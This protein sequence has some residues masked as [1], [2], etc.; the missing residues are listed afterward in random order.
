MAGKFLTF[1]AVLYSVTQGQAQ[2]RT[3]DPS[4]GANLWGIAN[5]WAEGTI[6]G[7]N[8][9]VIFNNDNG[10]ISPDFTVDLALDRTVLGVDLGGDTGFTFLDVDNTLNLGSGGITTS[11]PSSGSVTHVFNNLFNLTADQTWT[12]ADSAAL[13]INGII[14]STGSLTK[15]G[16]GLLTLEG[17]NTYTGGTTISAGTLDLGSSG[18]ITDSITNNGN[19]SFNRDSAGIDFSDILANDIN[20]AG[21]LT[22]G[23][24]KTL[25]LTGANT[26][27]GSTFLNAGGIQ[28]GNGGTQ[29]SLAGDVQAASGTSLS[30]NRS[31]TVTYGGIISGSGGVIQ[32][33]TGTTAFTN[34]HTYTGGTTVNAGSLSI[35][36]GGNR[37]AIAGNITNN[38]NLIINL[39]NTYE[40]SGVIS[41]TGTLDKFGNGLLELTGAN[42]FTGLTTV[43]AGILDIRSSG[44][45]NS[46]AIV[47]DLH[48]AGGATAAFRQGEE[49][50]Y[51]GSVSGEGDFASYNSKLILIGDVASTVTVFSLDHIQIGN[52]GTSG[53]IAGDV[54]IGIENFLTVNRSDAT[55]HSGILSG[56]EGIFVKDGAGTHTLNGANTYT[57]GTILNSGGLG[58][59]NNSA[60]GTGILTV[61]GGS[62]VYSDGVD[63]SNTIDLD[64]DLT[65]HVPANAYAT[66]SG[67]IRHTDTNYGIHKTGEG[68]LRL[69]KNNNFRG[70]SSLNGGTLELANSGALGTT[71]VNLTVFDGVIDLKA[72]FRRDLILRNDLIVNVDE[73]SDTT[74]LVE[75]ISEISGSHGFTK[76]G[77]GLL[78][79]DDFVSS[80]VSITGDITVES[81][82]LEFVD[83]AYMPGQ[84]VFLQNDSVLAYELSDE[85]SIQ[86]L[87]ETNAIHQGSGSLEVDGSAGLITAGGQYTV[88]RLFGQNTYSGGTTLR[89]G[90]RLQ[91][92]NNDALGTGTLTVIEEGDD[93]NIYDDSILAYEDG[94]DLPNAID[95]QHDLEV[96][97]PSGAT[98]THSG[99]IGET[100]GNYD[101]IKQG[102][103]TLE[104]TAFNT[105]EGNLIMNEGVI[106]IG[107]AETLESATVVMNVDNGLDVNDRIA[108]LG[109]LSGSGNFEVG[110]IVIGAN[111]SDTTYDGVMSGDT[112]SLTKVG[113]GKLTL[114]AA[115]DFSG[116]TS[117]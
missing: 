78:V 101:L 83:T 61:N 89:N 33:G 100:G 97:V 84:N 37:G 106:K 112:P 50:T 38:A 93:F 5:N 42:T 69:E 10:G 66:Q 9:T 107:L 67:L 22:K 114:T 25:I 90:G 20:G 80:R 96:S 30:F 48:I 31:D 109:G 86:P 63:I 81:G 2:T 41:G 17:T 57:G 46:G 85:D 23:G 27:T 103:G 56:P 28:I 110:S 88:L 51:G 21:T 15:A 60:L 58:L 117:S 75:S 71:A 74:F 32:S 52:G 40:Y 4:S 64:N 47:G 116:G 44:S 104:L 76:T 111:H 79:L 99:I 18:S 105:W 43:H 3:W 70:D 6:P 95:L 12:V 13:T 39:S 14:S 87:F 98:A 34:D 54:E 65:M 102:T 35:G 115:N 73:G 7:S 16:S 19:L 29:G 36:N 49:S 91:V 53:S 82:T 77:D 59:G 68:T 8:T 108:E 72:T 26:F 55:S 24:T 45:S 62:L 94:I 113:N 92:G 11:N 1:I